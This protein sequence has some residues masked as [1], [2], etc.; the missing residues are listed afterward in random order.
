MRYCCNLPVE[1]VAATWSASA[2]LRS[3]EHQNPA[4]TKRRCYYAAASQ[5]GNRDP[6]SS[7]TAR[8]LPQASRQAAPDASDSTN[9]TR[10]KIAR[11]G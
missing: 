11:Q 8:K 4:L 10:Q 9:V 7:R 2:A 3:D 6:L 1:T 5:A